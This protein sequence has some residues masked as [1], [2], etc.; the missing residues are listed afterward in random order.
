[1]ADSTAPRMPPPTRPAFPACQQ[2]HFTGPLPVAHTPPHAWA[3][4]AEEGETARESRRALTDQGCSGRTKLED[5][6]LTVALLG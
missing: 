3:T 5:S 6:P 2:P 4:A 1:M